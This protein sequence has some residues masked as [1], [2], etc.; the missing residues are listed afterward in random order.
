MKNEPN[1][2][3]VRTEKE[4][5]IFSKIGMHQE[6]IREI[7]K[8]QISNGYWN[9]YDERAHLEKM[10][11]SRFNFYILFYTAILLL[12]SNCPSYRLAALVF[13]FGTAITVIISLV[14]QRIY[15]KLNITLQILYALGENHCFPVI[16]SIMNYKRYG[17]DGTEQPKRSRSFIFFGLDS[18]E[19]T[20]FAM[21]FFGIGMFA[22]FTVVAFLMS[23]CECPSLLN[24]TKKVEAAVEERTCYDNTQSDGESVAKPKMVLHNMNTPESGDHAKPRIVCDDDVSETDTSESD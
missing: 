8:E 18:R 12:A 15:M 13:A 20:G 1:E 17:P 2:Y 14:T 23:F 16:K 5:E 4:K 3:I 19:Y 21:Q 6:K 9:F 7:Y 24:D 10:L 11:D 22:V